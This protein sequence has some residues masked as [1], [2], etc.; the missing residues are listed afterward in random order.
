MMARCKYSNR[1]N[2]Y[3]YNGIGIRI[4]ER[5]K[6]F[7][8]FLSDMGERPEGT[9]IDRINPN[10]DYCPENCRWATVLDQ[11]RNRSNARLTFQSAKEIALRV[12]RG[13]SPK[14]LS[15][16]FGISES[17]P[18]EIAKGRTWKDALEEAKNEYSKTA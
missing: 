5:W 13:E 2:S 14:K 4:C 16:E 8:N 18:R 17:L 7:V 11:A 1:H 12:L 3:R 15:L 9:T 6:V 10:G